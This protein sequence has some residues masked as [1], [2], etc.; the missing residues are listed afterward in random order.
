MTRFEARTL[1]YCLDRTYEETVGEPAVKIAREF[2]DIFMAA[3]KS[4]EAI[5]AQD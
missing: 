1:A 4:G 2:R 3:A 5:D